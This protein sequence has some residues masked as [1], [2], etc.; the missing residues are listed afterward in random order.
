MFLVLSVVVLGYGW[1]RLDF[2]IT[3]R[4][5]YRY[6]TVLCRAH[7]NKKC[8]K[9]VFLNEEKKDLIMILEVQEGFFLSRE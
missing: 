8:K 1:K 7:Q 3:V 5:K 4:A 9:P 6:T 2:D